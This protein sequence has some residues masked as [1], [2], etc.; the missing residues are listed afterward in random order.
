VPVPVSRLLERIAAGDAPP[1]VLVRGDLVL[2][3]PVGQRIAAALGERAGCP[4]ETHRRPPR[5]TPILEDLRTYSLFSPAK[6]LLVVAS[7]LLADRAAAADL[8]D[9]AA[10]GLPAGEGDLSPRARAA[11]ARLLQ[12]LRL[13]GIDPFEDEPRPTIDELPPWALEGGRALRRGRPRGRAKRELEDLRAGLAQL[14]AAARAAG[15]TGFAE[16]DLAELGA[17]VE[18]GLP[19]DHAL[20]LVETSAADDHPV[21]GMLDASGA[22]VD[23]GG[24]EATKEG[25]SGLGAL[26]A[27]LERQTG[28]RMSTSARDE[29]ARRTLR[30]EGGRDAGMAADSTARFA[31]EYRKLADLS[32]GATIQTELVEDAVEDRGQEDVWKLLD[33]IGEG[34][35]GDAL[36][37]LGRML[38]AAEDP[39][40]ARLQF[41]ASLASFCRRLTAVGGLLAV[42]GV[43]RGETNYNNFKSRIAPALQRELPDGTKNPLA[44]LHAFPLHRV[45]LAA[46][47]FDAL[48]LQRLPWRVLETELRIKGESGEAEAA[49]YEL[50]AELAGKR[51]PTKTSTARKWS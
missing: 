5:L 15:M 26:A 32:G 1:V 30:G 51:F 33:A 25:I 23:A 14:L 6:V 42:A 27:E 50:I 38:R 49:L 44:G 34:R 43:K 45:Y 37:R 48:T 20:V 29:L 39:L 17:I 2:A 19:R 4:V 22:V 36:D 24:V 11:A 28:T 13:F 9:E 31:A 7:S 40:A 8:V 18:G 12:A 46:S 21:V 16:G 10:D 41:F 3:E 35:A 47:R